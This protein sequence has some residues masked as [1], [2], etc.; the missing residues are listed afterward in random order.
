MKTHLITML[1]AAITIVKD[2]SFIRARLDL[3]SNK[4]NKTATNSKRLT[5]RRIS[6]TR[7][8]HARWMTSPASRP[9]SN[10]I[11]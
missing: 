10:N 9:Q 6:R 2:S 7:S 11:R 1:V 3:S 4:T 8:L 5:T